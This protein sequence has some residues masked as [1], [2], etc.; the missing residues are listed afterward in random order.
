MTSPANFNSQ[1]HQQHQQMNFNNTQPLKGILHNL[2]EAQQ[3]ASTPDNKRGNQGPPLNF[4]QTNIFVTNN[5]QVFGQPPPDNNEEHLKIEDP[6]ALFSMLPTRLQQNQKRLMNT[7][8][9]RGTGLLVN[10]FFTDRASADAESGQEE[11][12]SPNFRKRGEPSGYI[13]RA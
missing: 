1:V 12:E 8:T 5:N 6:D 10:N 2:K 4:T 13:A 9:T 11:Q 3:F 7:Q